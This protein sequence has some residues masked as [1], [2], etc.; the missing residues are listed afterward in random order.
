MWIGDVEAILRCGSQQDSDEFFA[1]LQNAS[2]HVN[3]T[4]LEADRK[5]IRIVVGVDDPYLGAFWFTFD[6]PLAVI[7]NPGENVVISG[8]YSSYNQEPLQIKMTNSSISVTP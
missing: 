7:P 1:V 6:G 4:V 3:G 8:T 5:S 2:V